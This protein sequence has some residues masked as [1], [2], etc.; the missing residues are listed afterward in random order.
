MSLLLLL[1][2]CA[3]PS[4]PW[5]VSSE[6]AGTLDY[7]DAT[8]AWGL[9]AVNGSQLQAVDLDGDG[10]PDL[11]AAD[12]SGIDDY[13]GGPRYHWLLMNRSDGA[14]GRMFVDETE[15]SGL[16]QRRSGTG[17]RPSIDHVFAD[18]DGDGDIDAFAGV[19]NDPHTDPAG[20]L[21]D[22]S[23]ILLND[24]TGRFTFAPV[25]PDLQVDFP[26]SGVTFTDHDGDG[27]VDLFIAL[28]YKTADIYGNGTW[29]NWLYGAN[30]R[31]LRGNGDGTFTDITVEA[32]LEMNDST[33]SRAQGK[34]LDG[35]HARPSMGATA[36]DLDGD[37]FPELLVMAY[38]RQW[39][40]HWKNQG[41]GTFVEMGAES[42]YAGDDDIDYTDNWYY[43]CHCW[44]NGTCDAPT[45]PA[46]PYNAAQCQ[47]IADGGY[48][49]V[50]W[51]DQPANLNGNTFNT[52]C[53]DIDDDG[54]LDL[55]N[56]E[57][58]HQWAGGSSD[59]SGLLLNNGAGHFT[60]PDLAELGLLR[61]PVPDP[62]TGAWDYGDQK[63]AFADLDLDGRKDLLL[64]SGAAYH[65]NVLHVWRQWDR[66]RFSEVQDDIGI[67]VPTAHGLAIAD[68]DRD[69]DLDLVAASLSETV[70]DSTTDHRLYFFQ[71]E[72]P[73]R[74]FLRVR[75]SAPISNSIGIGARVAVTAG[76]R[77]QVQEVIGGFGQ[78]GMQMEP[79]LTFGLGLGAEVDSVSVTWPGGTTEVFTGVPTDTQV[80]LESGGAVTDEGV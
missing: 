46:F 72:T 58:T 1:A 43:T 42:G 63:S 9:S 68:F 16:F 77:T 79:V 40:L 47:Q 50:G 35:T 10:Y 66:L 76:G 65:G 3:D 38:G 71:N 62:G 4:D 23:D 28:W 57:I 51:D 14:G 33:T 78:H 45:D 13:A 17:G 2:A 34:V 36:C 69:G 32:G 56:G 29:L 11:V 75:L 53:T 6:G 31:L 44:S 37:S 22:F 41:N 59:M 27:V 39:N 73:D 70:G 64:P 7:T 15:A 8:D 30:D 25:S 55:W 60:R 24:G 80:R 26:M 18:V 20:H 74:H 61:T 54:D 67:S 12:N 48:W 52:A 5:P 21:T 49:N 19:F